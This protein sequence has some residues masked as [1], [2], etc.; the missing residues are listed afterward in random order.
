[1]EKRI[2]AEKRCLMRN[3]TAIIF[4]C[5]IVLG[6]SFL[7]PLSWASSDHLHNSQ[8]VAKFGSTNNY[9]S[10]SGGWGVAGGQYG[11]FTCATCHTKGS[12]NSKRVTTSIPATIGPSVAKNIIYKN[13]TAFGYDYSGRTSSQR[14]CEAC[15]SVAKVHRYDT[16]GQTN[17][18]HMNANLTDCMACHPHEKG[19][20]V[21]GDC[22]TCHSKQLGS[23]TRQVGGVDS[24]LT[25]RHIAVTTPSEKSCRVCHEQTTFGHNMTGDVAVGLYDQDTGTTVSYDGTTANNGEIG[26]VTCHDANGAAR[27]GANA[28]KPFTDS[29]DDTV[30]LNIGWTSGQMAHSPKMACFNCHGKSGAANTTLDP[31]YNA[32]GSATASMLQDTNY[33]ADAPNNYCFNCHATAS[34]NANKAATNISGQFGLSY[35]HTS[36]DC[37]DCHGNP[38]NGVNSIHKLKAGN[39]TAGSTTIAG[40]LASAIGKTVTFGAANWTA[41]TLGTDKT[42]TSEHEICLKCHAAT[43]LP[44]GSGAA[45]YTN[46]GLEFN[47]L[48]KSTHPVALALGAAGSGSTT[49]NAVQ[50]GN[51]WTPGMVMTCSDCHATDQTGGYGPHGSSTKWMLKGTY[52]NWPYTASSANG[53]SGSTYFYLGASGGIFCQNCH[54]NLNSTSSSLTN[55]VHTRGVHRGAISNGNCVGCHIRVPHGGKVSRLI[56]ADNTGTGLPARY[57]PDGNGGGTVFLKKFSKGVWS[58]YAKSGCYSTD[59]ACSSGHNNA[60][61]GSESW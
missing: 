42:A 33:S 8:T 23:G 26:C 40:N 43:T 46:L 11:T 44:S 5:C 22:V 18:N 38:S 13:V 36:A 3:K 30:P 47:P 2:A 9:W 35:K 24:I 27:L 7:M 58:T 56:A 21:D 16:T 15:H 51:G 12:S 6:L 49:L 32:H 20:A 1:M 10:A 4:C 50:V 39:H 59:T 57:Y 61:Y 17:Y 54:P 31:K 60:T 37:Y 53:T 28:T 14:I 41:A 34:T 19:F 52:K 55:R 25:H 48:N 29:G 45:S